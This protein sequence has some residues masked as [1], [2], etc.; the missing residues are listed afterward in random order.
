MT[1][2]D[3]LPTSKEEF[4]E[5]DPY[6]FED[7]IAW[8]WEHLGNNTTVRQGSGDR[9]IDIEVK[10][11]DG[12]ALKLIQAKRYKKSNKLGSPDVRKYATLYQQQPNAEEVIIV[13]TSTF[14]EEAKRLGNDLDVTLVDMDVL[15][16]LYT[17]IIS[18]INESNKSNQSGQDTPSNVVKS[19]YDTKLSMVEITTDMIPAYKLQLRNVLEGK[20]VDINEKYEYNGNI[21]E[22]VDIRPKGKHRGGL[23]TKST[24]IR[25]R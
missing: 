12:N 9:G 19:G 4:R 6:Y 8:I 18:E 15:W 24:N 20:N 5:L 16:N 17:K 1:D 10:S 2:S 14:T 22:I 25:F 11:N 7:L 23:I 3:S 21:F 13:T